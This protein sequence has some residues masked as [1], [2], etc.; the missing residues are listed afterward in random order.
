MHPMLALHALI[1]LHSPA[2]LCLH[3]V[4]PGLDAMPAFTFRSLLD[5]L[6]KRGYEFLTADDAI[7]AGVLRRNTVLL[8][9]DDGRQDNFEVVLPILREYRIRAT[10]YVCP[11][12]AGKQAAF[13][14]HPDCDDAASGN[15][16]FEMMNWDVL[17]QLQDS[18]MCIGSHTANHPD[19]T[20]C[21]EEQLDQEIAGS[22][23][24]LERQLQVPVHHFSY[25]WGRFNAQVLR[26]VRA[27]GYKTAAAVS[28]NPLSPIRPWDAFTLP[29]VTA[30]P[31]AAPE[32]LL[33]SISFPNMFRRALSQTRRLPPSPV[34]SG[35]S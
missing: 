21:P 6:L 5:G 30:H 12:L 13:A 16:V 14:S 32:E 22:K 29:R 3:S 28:V 9:F 20:Q 26:R 18:G 33:R 23:A 35:I 2:I 1:R 19:L 10:F 24:A 25:P 8:T 15:L 4:G 27:A 31:A 11:G 7:R 34:W 17:R